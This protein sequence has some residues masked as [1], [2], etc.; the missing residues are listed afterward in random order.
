MPDP[1]GNGGLFPNP[2]PTH[3][4]HARGALSDTTSTGETNLCR[5]PQSCYFYTQTMSLTQCP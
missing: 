1:F 3:S 4:P 5:L 2:Q